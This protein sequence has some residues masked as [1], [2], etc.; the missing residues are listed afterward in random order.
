DDR[1]GQRQRQPF[2]RGEPVGCLDREVDQRVRGLRIARDLAVVDRQRRRPGS[3]AKQ[4][5]EC[6][7]VVLNRPAHP[8]PSAFTARSSI[9][10]SNR[11]CS[12]SAAGRMNGIGGLLTVPYSATLPSAPWPLA[13][14]GP[15]S[16]AGPLRLR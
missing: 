5:Q 7:A 11:G 13:W 6:V 1:A 12:A 8:S 4:R 15:I 14:F 2:R 3:S 9:A 16:A 10:F